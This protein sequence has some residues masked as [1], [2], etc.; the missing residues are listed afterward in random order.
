MLAT[1]YS[2][3]RCPKTSCGDYGKRLLL[4]VG[5]DATAGDLTVKHRCMS[6]G[7]AEYGPANPAVARKRLGGTLAALLLR[8]RLEGVEIPLRYDRSQFPK[9]DFDD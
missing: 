8:Q 1:E 3:K 4:D 5:A 7:Y 2:W 9:G 6:C